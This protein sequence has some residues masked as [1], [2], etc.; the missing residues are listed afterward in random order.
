MTVS[1]VWA[2]LLEGRPSALSIPSPYYFS[3]LVFLLPKDTSFAFL[4][5]LSPSVTQHG[6]VA[7]F[8][9]LQTLKETRVAVLSK[10]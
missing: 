5:S 4:H 8:F 9:P 2:S 7:S 3:T 1:Q 6:C 10:E